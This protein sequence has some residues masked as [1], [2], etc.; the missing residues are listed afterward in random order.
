MNFY[1]KYIK[2]KTKY[3]NSLNKLQYG[4]GYSQ[5]NQSLWDT[6]YGTGFTARFNQL[7]KIGYYQD[8]DMEQYI[9][10]IVDDH[11]DKQ[12][13][14]ILSLCSGFARGEAILCKEFND[15]KRLIRTDTQQINLFLYDKGYVDVNK[16]HIRDTTD[17]LIR[18]HLVSSVRYL[19][20]KDDVIRILEQ[21]PPTIVMAI[22]PFGGG[23][24]LY[25]PPN[26][27]QY[28]KELVEIAIKYFTL[29]KFTY[30]IMQS[31]IIANH[32]CYLLMNHRFHMIRVGEM[33]DIYLKQHVLMLP[34]FIQALREIPDNAELMKKLMEIKTRYPEGEI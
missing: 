3:I 1:N 29:S 4:S 21:N 10:R 23:P 7:F 17:F 26:M 14:N 6:T 24:Q 9:S 33:A 12:I 11:Q 34:L 19:S 22:N 31:P 20:H 15:R 28:Y 5:G 8:N 27:L 32:N 13:I 25:S 18:N 30:D 2:Y 16:Y